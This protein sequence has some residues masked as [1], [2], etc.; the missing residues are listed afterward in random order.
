MNVLMHYQV[1][2]KVFVL[3]K[4]YF[5]YEKAIIRSIFLQLPMEYTVQT[6]V[7]RMELFI[8]CLYISTLS[9]LWNKNVLMALVHMFDHLSLSLFCSTTSSLPLLF[10]ILFLFWLS[11]GVWTH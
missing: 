3:K 8:N 1:S 10:I 2:F 6:L 11:N 5:I 4:S 7:Q 9:S